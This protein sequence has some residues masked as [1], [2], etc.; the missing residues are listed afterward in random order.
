LLAVMEVPRVPKVVSL[1][2]NLSSSSTWVRA[3]A[4]L[5]SPPA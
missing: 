5:A 1:S 4:T 2:L 3:L